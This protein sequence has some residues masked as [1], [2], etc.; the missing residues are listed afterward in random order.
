MAPSGAD[1]RSQFYLN[2]R[3]P[4]GYSPHMKRNT[5]S[6]TSTLSRI[7][8][9]RDEALSDFDATGRLAETVRPNRRN[10]TRQLMRVKGT[11]DRNQARR[12]GAEFSV[13]RLVHDRLTMPAILKRYEGQLS[14]MPEQARLDWLERLVSHS[15]ERG[16]LERWTF[17]VSRKMRSHWKRAERILELQ[18]ASGD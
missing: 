15:H 3:E 4:I 2:R 5:L 14:I 17:A 16:P 8:L 1:R 13:E 7:K 12:L 9:A 11:D 10:K 18:Q 6:N